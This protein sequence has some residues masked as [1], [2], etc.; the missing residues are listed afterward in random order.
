MIEWLKYFFGG[1]WSNE[2][3]EQCQYRSLGNTALGALLAFVLLV[4]GLTWGYQASFGS[5]YRSAE[6]FRSFLYEALEQS[7]FTITDG[8]ATGSVQV[9][10]YEKKQD[11][12][13]LIIDLR[14]TE[15]LYDDFL[16]M[17]KSEKRAEI[18]Y[19]E[20]LSQPA[21]IQQDYTEFYV[22]YSGRILDLQANYETY[23]AYL[24]TVTSDATSALYQKDIAESFTELEKSKPADYYEQIYLLY[25]KAY[26]P[27]FT[28]REYGAKA[29]TLHG[30]YLAR[31]EGDA[32]GKLLALFREKC[33][34]G[35]GAG[36]R[37]LFFAGDYSHISTLQPGKAGA[38]ELILQA[39]RSGNQADY[40]MY[41]VNVFGFFFIIIIG[42]LLLTIIV[43]LV[44]RKRQLEATR[45]FGGAAQLIGSFLLWSSLLTAI[46]VFLLSF[47]LSQTM[48]YY[49][50]VALV[51][52]IM[53][54]R[55]IIFLH[56]Q[57]LCAEQ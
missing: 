12:Y 27:E 23:Y 31:I 17:C 20:Y 28:L 47:V 40:L 33:Y 36:N 30:F 46:S 49:L 8:I 29:P 2:R 51:L 24:Q 4:C 3:S 21:H 34:V 50:S 57:K 53:I 48:V 32:E 54:V 42:W 52:L 56:S 39:F 15:H 38:D 43:W 10:T 44:S 55:A 19:E 5:A 26:Y 41:I 16:M 25:V 22:G 6:E 13:Q 18:T 45:K 11:G 7:D 1:F 9:N 14:D 35:F 37:E